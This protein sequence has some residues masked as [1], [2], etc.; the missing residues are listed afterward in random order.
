MKIY[1]ATE[2]AYKNGY[3]KGYETAKP[4]WIPVAER[5]PNEGERVLAFYQDGVQRVQCTDCFGFPLVQTK[6][7]V[8]VMVT[9]WMPLPKPPKE[10]RRWQM[11]S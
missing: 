9:H 7:L 5:M 6:D 4:K 10:G 8:W 3:E 11:K 2:Q 1:E